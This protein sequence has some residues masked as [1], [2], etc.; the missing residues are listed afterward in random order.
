MSLHFHETV[1]LI[2]SF[3][4]NVHIMRA[5]NADG[6]QALNFWLITSGTLLDT[7]VIEWCKLFGNDDGGHQPA[8]WKNVIPVADHAAFRASQLK[9][10]GVTKSEWNRYWTD[11]LAYRN[12]AVAHFDPRPSRPKNYPQFDLAII[13][14]C[15]YYEWMMELGEPAGLSRGYPEDIKVYCAYFAKQ[16]DEIAR[17]ALAATAHIKEPL[18]NGFV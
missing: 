4:R 11:M 8:H 17:V 2:V 5:L 15:H 9:A 6:P 16:S 18:G 3:I 7:S 14:A 10:L 12:K 1:G 13:A